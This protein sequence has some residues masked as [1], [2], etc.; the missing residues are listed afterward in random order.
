MKVFTSKNQK[1]GQK[2]EYFARK[3]LVKR[4]FIIT[5]CNYTKKCGEI[6]IVALLGETIHF[7]EVKALT[8]ASFGDVPRETL[9]VPY[10]NPL[11]NVTRSKLLKMKR[12]IGCYLWERGVPRETPWVVDVVSVIVSR[13]TGGARV[14]ILGDVVI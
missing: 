4:G 13:E 2:G 9:K 7:I 14:S 5:E 1:I 12:A 8:V 6:D 10:T 11:E 3:F